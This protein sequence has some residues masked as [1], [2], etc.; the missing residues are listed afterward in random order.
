MIELT[1]VTKADGPLTKRI[2][3]IPSGTVISDGS[4]CIMARGSAKR[5]RLPDCRAFAE[6]LDRL[7]PNEALT[8]GSLYPD[9]PERVEI[10]T[11]AR[12]DALNGAAHPGIIARTLGAHWLSHGAAGVGVTRR[13]YEGHAFGDQGSRADHGRLSG[14]SRFSSP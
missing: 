8:L 6:M 5:V 9:L 2:S 7:A 1:L 3:L 10:T 13:G 14:G 12:L 4:A 11:K